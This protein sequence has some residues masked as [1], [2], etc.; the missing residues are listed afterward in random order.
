MSAPVRQDPRPVIAWTVGLVALTVA[1]M[2]AMYLARDVILLIYISIVL[3]IGFGPI[4]RAV[5]R[6]PLLVR[7]RRVP[8][9]LGRTGA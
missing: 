8:R 9:W 1:V 2:W 6:R 3:C 4:V 7:K 5:E